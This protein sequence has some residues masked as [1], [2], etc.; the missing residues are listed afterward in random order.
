MDTRS[1]REIVRTV[2]VSY[3]IPFRFALLIAVLLFCFNWRSRFA[4][5]KVVGVRRNGYR[6]LSGG[7]WH[8]H[9]CRHAEAGP[10]TVRTVQSG[11]PLY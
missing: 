3:P 4:R 9:I 2:T 8:C 6:L 7:G 5:A 11:E 10:A 1:F